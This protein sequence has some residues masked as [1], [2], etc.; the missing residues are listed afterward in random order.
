VFSILGYKINTRP[1]NATNDDK[2]YNPPRKR[3]LAKIKVV[4][5]NDRCIYY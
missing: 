3:R 4:N 1:V 2:T 5:F